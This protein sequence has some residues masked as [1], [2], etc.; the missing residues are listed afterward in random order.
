MV[1]WVPELAAAGL[2]DLPLQSLGVCE[3]PLFSPSR[4]PESRSL[5]ACADK[6]QIFQLSMLVFSICVY[7]MSLKRKCP[8]SL[9]V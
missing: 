2:F 3:S 9:S 5:T 1:E 4:M 6:L 7:V 8:Q